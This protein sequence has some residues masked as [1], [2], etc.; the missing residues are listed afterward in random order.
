MTKRNQNGVEGQMKIEK[1]RANIIVSL[2]GVL[3]LELWA[4]ISKVYSS[5]FLKNGKRMKR[6]TLKFQWMN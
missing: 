1:K 3:D 4:T 2:L 6:R 5:Q